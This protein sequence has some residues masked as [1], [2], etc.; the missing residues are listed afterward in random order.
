MSAPLRLVQEAAKL[1][2]DELDAL[3]LKLS[4]LRAVQP[5]RGVGEKV[6]ARY[7]FHSPL[8][9]ALRHRLNSLGHHLP[10]CNEFLTYSSRAKSFLVEEEAF[11]GWLVPMFPQ[12][13]TPINK[14]AIAAWFADLALPH[15]QESKNLWV[16]ILMTVRE[17]P[18]VIDQDFPGYA[19]NGWL[20][21]LINTVLK[22]GNHVRNESSIQTRTGK[23]PVVASA[24]GVSHHTR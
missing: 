10:S 5:K 9:E 24:G 1:T 18:H 2:S 13:N 15:I 14:N 21:V 17:A 16:G 19:Q 12:G 11:W 3:I 23:R 4:C 8:Y 6:F 7:E 22:G 20:P